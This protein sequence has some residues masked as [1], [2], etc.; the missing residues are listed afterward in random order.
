MSVVGWPDALL[1][2]AHFSD[3]CLGVEL[4]DPDGKGVERF[5]DVPDE[6]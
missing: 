3:R 2:A 6:V 5:G 1:A 4:L